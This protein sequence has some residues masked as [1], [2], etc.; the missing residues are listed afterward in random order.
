MIDVLYQTQRNLSSRKTFLRI[1]QFHPMRFSELQESQMAVQRPVLNL[2]QLAG[3]GTL[4]I[5]KALKDRPGS[6]SPSSRVAFV[7]CTGIETSPS[8]RSL[9]QDVGQRVS[10]AASPSKHLKTTGF[11]LFLVSA[12]LKLSQVGVPWGSLYKR[13]I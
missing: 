9:Q 2:S 5:F 4:S 12:P 11:M 7:W 6:K 3:D 10:L 13:Y 1:F 8:D